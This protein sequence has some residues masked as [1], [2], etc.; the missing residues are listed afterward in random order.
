MNKIDENDKEEMNE[1]QRIN[2]NKIDENTKESM[3]ERQR[4]MIECEN[5]NANKRREKKF[6]KEVNDPFNKMIRKNRFKEHYEMNK[7]KYPDKG[8]FE[9]WY[10]NNEPSYTPCI[11]LE[12]LTYR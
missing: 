4:I 10:K 9:E 2:I 12:A 7:H 5:I 8:D 3:N 1:I 11:G 6:N